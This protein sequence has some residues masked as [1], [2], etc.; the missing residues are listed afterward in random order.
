[1]TESQRKLTETFADVE[2]RLVEQV[3]RSVGRETSRLTEEASVEF[4]SAVR[5]TVEEAARRLSRELD[6]SIESFVKQAD[7][8]L[9][10]RLAEFTDTAG[11]RLERRYEG[12]ITALERRV[13]E[14]ETS[15][16]AGTSA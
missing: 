4:N 14:L 11:G 6:R 1:L 13:A 7:R 8:L 9:A 15:L 10:E 16:R 2:R 5:A 12:T 3:E